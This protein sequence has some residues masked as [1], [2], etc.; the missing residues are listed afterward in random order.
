VSAPWTDLGGG[1]RVRQS[2]RYAM[3]GVVL[4]HAEHTVVVDPGILPGELDDLASVVS[5]VAPQ[6]VTLV[7]THAHW[8][9]VLGRSWW[10]S[11]DTLAHDG[12]A[13]ALKTEVEYV[14]SEA[15]RIAGE[16]GQRW[17]RRFEPFAPKHAVSGL[18][19][20]KLGPWRL[21]FR[22]APGHCAN[23][24]NVHLPEPRILIAA[25]MLSDIEIPGLDAPPD[26]YRSSLDQL[27]PIAHGGAIETL[28]P[29]H[30]SI[31]RGREAVLA[32]LQADLDY[33]DAIERGAHE[34][35]QSG[36][37]AD[38]AAERLA[39]MEYAGKHAQEYPTEEIHRDNVR[40]AHRALTGAR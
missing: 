39:S 35:L 2:A 21:V 20:R 37:D 6:A 36:L 32:R 24:I 30:G 31:A 33:L 10:P 13:A 23:Q 9:H 18:H 29:G 3:N 22:S 40:R 15:E 27:L 11:A 1:V 38:A 7:F 12:F 16:A 19:F 17:P 5:S 8:D 14:R 28:V 34:A 25:D 26:I 4:L